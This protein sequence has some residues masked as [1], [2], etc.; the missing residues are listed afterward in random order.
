MD[1]IRRL[2][3]WE[4]LRPIVGKFTEKPNAILLFP[5][6]GPEILTAG[7]GDCDKVT[8]SREIVRKIMDVDRAVRAEVVIE[9]KQNVHPR[10]A[11]L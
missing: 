8:E 7:Y 6:A 11:K 3:I 2:G 9:D 1:D 10:V 4:K 5:E